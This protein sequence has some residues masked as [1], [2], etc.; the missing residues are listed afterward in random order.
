MN[1]VFF[2]GLVAGACIALAAELFIII[3]LLLI[4]LYY[5]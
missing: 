3:I 2:I 1:V 4:C 5:R